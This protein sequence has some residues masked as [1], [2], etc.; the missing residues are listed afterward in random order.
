[1]QVVDGHFSPRI[2]SAKQYALIKN[3]LKVSSIDPWIDVPG[4]ETLSMYNGKL[5]F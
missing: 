4:L 2:L 1:M 3:E 5:A